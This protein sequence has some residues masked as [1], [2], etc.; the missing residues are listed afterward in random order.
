MVHIP[1][2][3]LRRLYVAHSLKNQGEGFVFQFQNKVTEGMLVGLSQL[4]VDGVERSLEGA[5]ISARDEERPIVQLTPD[6]PMTFPAGVTVTFHVAG[7]LP[8]GEHT[9]TFTLQTREIGPVP[10]SI[11]DT[12]AA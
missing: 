5:T 11:A 2:A 6:R 4:V 7:P 10:F 3:L 12:V 1:L 9:I 8:P